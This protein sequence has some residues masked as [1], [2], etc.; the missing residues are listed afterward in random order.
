MIICD[1][2]HIRAERLYVLH[3]NTPGGSYVSYMCGDLLTVGTLKHAV[4]VS[5]RALS[6]IE[7]TPHVAPTVQWFPILYAN[8]YRYE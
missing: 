5:Y 4:I 1:F 2:I 6:S 8:G 3:V 7:H